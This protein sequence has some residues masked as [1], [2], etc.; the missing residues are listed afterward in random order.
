MED[1]LAGADWAARDP[2]RGGIEARGAREA[3]VPPI[4]LPGVDS[5]TGTGDEK[6][7]NADGPPGVDKKSGGGMSS[8]ALK[9]LGSKDGKVGA[10]DDEVELDDADE[11]GPDGRRPR[12]KVDDIEPAPLPDVPGNS[13]GGRVDEAAAA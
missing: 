9:L 5:G 8:P 12:G 11:A 10:V 13:C 1:I 7:G 3:A 2:A 6:E 4:V